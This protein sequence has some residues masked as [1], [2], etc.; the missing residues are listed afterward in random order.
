MIVMLAIIVGFLAGRLTWLGLRH[1]FAQ[2]VFERENFR[3]V[4]VPTAC[5][6]VIVIAVLTVEGLRAAMGALGLGPASSE[7]AARIAVVI[8]AAG[9]GLAGL[10]DDLAGSGHARG[11]R[12]HV[13]SMA[14]GRMTTGGLKLITGIAVSLVAV[15]AAHPIGE[16]SLAAVAHLL[17]DAALVALSANLANLFDR[18]PGRTGKVALAAFAALAIATTAAA[19]LS[20]VAVVI[21]ATAAL[22]P[23]DLK[24]R[25]MLG[26]TGANVIGAALGLGVVITCAPMTRLIVLGVV[27]ALNLLSEVV[28]FSRVIERVGVLRALDL[29]G[30]P[31]REN[32][33]VRDRPSGAR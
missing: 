20:G 26:D 27:L 33:Q 6:L 15:S 7:S 18:A 16:R 12:G 24:E 9:M 11:F 23:D 2:P 4:M 22:L 28:S 25:A 30:R 31:R 8:V 14:R 3:G 21:G 10:L 13:Q 17:A 19:S 29:A 1:S 32:D 5:G